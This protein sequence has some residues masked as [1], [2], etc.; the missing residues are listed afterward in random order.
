MCSSPVAIEPL[1]HNEGA[2]CQDLPPEDNGENKATGGT[3][4]TIVRQPPPPQF[5]HPVGSLT[6]RV[7]DTGRVYDTG[8]T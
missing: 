4:A 6:G 5:M 7:H 2:A 8:E 3:Q 1:H